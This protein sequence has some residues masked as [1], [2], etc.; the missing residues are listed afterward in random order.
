MK[1]IFSFGG[2]KEGQDAAAEQAKKASIT[3]DKYKENIE[4]TLKKIDQNF[5]NIRQDEGYQGLVTQ[6][7]TAY[8]TWKRQT[9]PSSEMGLIRAAHEIILFYVQNIINPALKQIEDLTKIQPK[10]NKQEEVDLS[11]N[12]LTMLM[13]IDRDILTYNRQLKELHES[14]VNINKYIKKYDEIKKEHFQLRKKDIT[15]EHNFEKDILKNLKLIIRARAK[16]QG[17][18]LQSKTPA[19]GIR[20]AAGGDAQA[21]AA[22]TSRRQYEAERARSRTPSPNPAALNAGWEAEVA[23]SDSKVNVLVAELEAEKA[24]ID[25]ELQ[26]LQAKNEEL[27][28]KLTKPMHSNQDS[29]ERE[30]EEE[31]AAMEAAKTAAGG[32]AVRAAVRN[33]ARA[34]SPGSESSRTGSDADSLFKEQAG[35]PAALGVAWLPAA[36]S[37]AGGADASQEAEEEIRAAAWLPAA[38]SPAGGARSS[39]PGGGALPQPGAGGGVVPLSNPPGGSRNAI[40]ARATTPPQRTSSPGGALPQPGAGGGG[41]PLSN[42]PGAGGDSPAMRRQTRY[43]VIES[44]NEKQIYFLINI[45]KGLQGKNKEEVTT[46]LTEIA[47]KKSELYQQVLRDDDELGLAYSKHFIDEFYK[48]ENSQSTQ[49]IEDLIADNNE[50]RVIKTIFST[51]KTR[52]QPIVHR[53]GPDQGAKE[54]EVKTGCIGRVF[55]R[56][57]EATRKPE[58]DDISI[59]SSASYEAEH[60]NGRG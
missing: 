8:F 45:A 56:K 42:P 16:K 39:S 44:I 50:L 40:E 22:R 18:Y 28:G 60:G 35:A 36:E 34:S 52:Q 55:S 17:I 58:D 33:S 30:A 4:K 54:D 25:K 19:A 15:E 10:A 6:Y 12:L 27:A 2:K 24:L 53:D 7:Q 5:E 31:L 11:T 38:E 47:N 14:R 13:Y 20:E 1:K 51:I 48:D 26:A 43:E 9:T 57:T 41:G 46:L 59:A 3:F 21:V 37:R 49:F 29:L 23:L 32:D